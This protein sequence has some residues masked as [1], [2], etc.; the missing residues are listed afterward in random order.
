[1]ECLGFNRPL[2]FVVICAAVYLDYYFIGHATFC[3]QL[4]Q[5]FYAIGMDST[6]QY[7][8][9]L[10]MTG[11]VYQTANY[12]TSWSSGSEYCF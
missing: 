10:T 7:A 11:E 9:F 5:E 8:T 4:P 3:L 6:G 2:R 12:G 1:M